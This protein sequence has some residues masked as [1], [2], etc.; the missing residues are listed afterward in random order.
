M[1][2]GQALAYPSFAGVSGQALGALQPVHQPGIAGQQG[3]PQASGGIHSHASAVS[4]PAQLNI[5]PG[6]L[7]MAEFPGISIDAAAGDL[8]HDL[9]GIGQSLPFSGS[10][11]NLANLVRH[12]LACYSRLSISGTV[13]AP[14]KLSHLERIPAYQS[15]SYNPLW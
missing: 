6:Q 5:D 7:S 9:A 15:L 12:F 2:P 13:S 14:K 4:Q 10:E 8:P 1:H 3:Q 11:I